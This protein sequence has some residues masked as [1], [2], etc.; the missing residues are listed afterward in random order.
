MMD[1]ATEETGIVAAL[2]AA[3][4]QVGAIPK[5]RKMQQGQQYAY[6]SIEQITPKVHE[7]FVAHG[8][9]GTPEVIASDYGEVP[10]KSGGSMRQAT[11]TVRWTFTAVDGSSVSC[12]VMGEATDSG[13]K[14]SNKAMTAA[15]KYALVQVLCI[16]LEDA[17]DP[18]HDRMERGQAKAKPAADK[19]PPAAVPDGMIETRAAKRELVDAC[20]ALGLTMDEAKAEAAAVWKRANIA[21]GPIPDEK[22]R[23]MIA[24]LAE[25]PP[26]EIER[27]DADG[28]TVEYE[29][30]TEPF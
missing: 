6:R 20:L 22:L 23:R 15:Q 14:A 24:G 9:V 25:P 5:G 26:V 1:A 2:V 3:S 11:L 27:S 28:P 12:V 29:P 4:A 10:T 21:A 17:D 30:G 13:D 16:P 8:I 7:A 19:P 18:D